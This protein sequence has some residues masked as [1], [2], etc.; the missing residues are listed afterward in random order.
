MAYELQALPVP[1]EHLVP[2]TGVMHMT[3]YIVGCQ[4]EAIA[5][6]GDYSERAEVPENIVPGAWSAAWRDLNNWNLHHNQPPF[7]QQRI[8]LLVRA[9]GLAMRDIKTPSLLIPERFYELPD[10]EWQYIR[11]YFMPRINIVAA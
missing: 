5:K 11:G 8:R 6:Y 4:P 2:V 3:S 10:S 1:S 9:S 7:E